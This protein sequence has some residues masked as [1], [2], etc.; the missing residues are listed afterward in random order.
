MPTYK[1]IYYADGT[2]NM[3]NSQISYDEAV[4]YGD[5]I[6]E[7]ALSIPFS[8]ADAAERDSK[9]PS[10]VDGTAVWRADLGLEQRYTT[11]SPAGWYTA[12][13]GMMLIRPDD[14]VFGG[15]TSGS[16]GTVTELGV[17]TFTNKN[18]VYVNGIFGPAFRNYK[19][20]INI[21]NTGAGANI[22][23]QFTDDGVANSSALYSYSS[24]YANS[25]TVSA[26]QNLV[27]TNSQVIGGGIARNALA[28][29]TLFAP[30]AGKPSWKIS[31]FSIGN[32]PNAPFLWNNHGYFNSATAAFDGIVFYTGSADMT[33]SI[34]VYG[35]N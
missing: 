9:Y 10:P 24:Y 21:K 8:V 12:T 2:S 22:N 26:V 34:M 11:S 28:E 19:F 1:N 16:S 25:G 32:T 31:G 20:L 4:S 33:G 30:Y 15:T 17:I 13:T 27:N 5:G 14:F 18:T 7:V 35:F 6:D 23:F 29:V 3:S